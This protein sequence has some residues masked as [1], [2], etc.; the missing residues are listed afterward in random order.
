MKVFFTSSFT[1]F[2]GYSLLK[3]G[4]RLC[5]IWLQVSDCYGRFGRRECWWLVVHLAPRR[6]YQVAG[7]THRLPPHRTSFP[8]T[9]S[10]G[11]CRIPTSLRTG[12]T[13]A[14]SSLYGSLRVFSQRGKPSVV[15]QILELSLNFLGCPKELSL[16]PG[17]FHSKQK[18]YST[19]N[20]ID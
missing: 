19:L 7:T 11:S 6:G 12:H 2:G 10:P 15:L 4:C 8:P 14:A 20:T 16:R 17:M 13:A 5:K 1:N 9:L 3:I 18:L